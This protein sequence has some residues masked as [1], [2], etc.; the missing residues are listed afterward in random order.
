M[1][2]DSLVED[3]QS[4]CIF[5]A[6]ACAIYKAYSPLAGNAEAA[7]ELSTDASSNNAVDILFRKNAF[8]KDSSSDLLLRLSIPTK[9]KFNKC[10]MNN[11][12]MDEDERTFAYRMALHESGHAL[13]TSGFDITRIWG[14]YT[15]AHPGISDSVMNYETEADCSPQPFD[16][17]AI[18][19]LYQNVG[20]GP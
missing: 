10:L 5:F 12:V 4:G 7:T 20:L 17:L 13:G 6:S 11:R 8:T 1:L 16:I 9:V 19:A 15:T 18:Y 2:R 3:F 14:L